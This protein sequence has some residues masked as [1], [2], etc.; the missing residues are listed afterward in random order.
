[1]ASKTPQLPLQPKNP[2]M[3]NMAPDGFEPGPITRSYIL[4]PGNVEYYFADLLAPVLYNLGMSPNA[5]TLMNCFMVRIPSIYIFVYY[6]NF[7]LFLALLLFSGI[8]DCTDGQIARRYKCGSTFGA[9]LDHVSDNIY[10]CAVT[11]AALHNIYIHYGLVSPEFGLV[12]TSALM[13]C[14]VG[15]NTIRV[16]EDSICWKDLTRLQTLGV[17]QEWYLFYVYIILFEYLIMTNTIKK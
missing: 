6:R 16:K 7:Q 15:Q 1:M 3:L 10:A 5:V 12:I 17:L 2:P 14:L 8:L 13:L 4:C 9:K 11:A